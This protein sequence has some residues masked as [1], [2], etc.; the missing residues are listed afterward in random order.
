MTSIASNQIPATS[1][2]KLSVIEDTLYVFQLSDFPFS[3]SD[4]GQTL[5][6]VKFTL[7]SARGNFYL[8]GVEIKT[9][10]EISAADI[11]DGALTYM[12]MKNAFGDDSYHFIFAVSD[13]IEYSAP[14]SGGFNIS[15]VEDQP[16]LHTSTGY[17]IDS[18]GHDPKYV[19]DSHQLSDG[20]IYIS[21]REFRYEIGSH[22][23]LSLHIDT[24]QND[25]KTELRKHIDLDFKFGNQNISATLLLPDGK[26]LVTGD[27]Y[28]SYTKKSQFFVSRFDSHGKLDKS[29]NVSGTLSKDMTDRVI[30]T[31]VILQSDGKYLIATK[32]LLK[33][34][35]LLS[36]LVL[37]RYNPDGSIDSEFN[38]SNVSPLIVKDEQEKAFLIQT[39]GKIL[40]LGQ[41][42][43]GN[44]IV[45]TRLN[46]DGTLDQRFGTNGSVNLQIERNGI[47]PLSMA[48][49]QDGKVLLLWSGR[50]EQN[51][52]EISIARLNPDGSLDT[53]F[54]GTGK[55]SLLND[56]LGF[57]VNE[58]KNLVV[59]DD[60]KIII[61][62]SGLKS[63]DTN[64]EY[65]DQIFVI[66]LVNEGRLDNS[67]DADGVLTL[68]L[69]A[70]AESPLNIF[71][72]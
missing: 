68:S 24:F 10:Q 37:E 15:S 3:D 30:N 51:L 2:I 54:N 65:R 35:S 70:S 42:V 57:F 72:D 60:Q 27:I 47:T 5:K 34:G 14:K 22:P 38:Q 48:V 4:V 66:R 40:L 28:D 16:I 23:Y 62:G 56:E 36:T 41:N 19:I 39:D 9:N 50:S 11:A 67:F 8:R 1:E 25:N 33:E 58:V 43:S 52:N 53:N 45:M 21:K 71:L 63:L 55:L 31:D 44:A 6:F 69:E 20:S 49:Q 64:E 26:V 46:T 13:G 32:S 12:P 59:T 7:M 29:F 18:F 17:L 61:S